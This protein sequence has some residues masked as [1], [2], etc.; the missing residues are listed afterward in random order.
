MGGT[1]YPDQGRESAAAFCGR[2]AGRHQ[3]IATQRR[4]YPARGLCGESTRLPSAFGPAPR[5]SG[6]PRP[7]TAKELEQA[8]RRPAS[9]V[10][11]EFETGLDRRI[12]GDVGDEPGNLPLL[13]FVL[14]ELW[15]NRQRGQLL[16]DS[17]D[18]MGGLQG[19]V[20]AKAEALFE[21][22]SPPEQEATRRLFLQLVHTA[23]EG[24]DTCRRVAI[25]DVA[26]T[27]AGRVVLKKLADARLVTTSGEPEAA[28]A[29][30]AHEALISGWRR[31]G[32]WVNENRERSRL[33][34]RLFD[35]AREWQKNGK[36]R[37]FLY[38]GAQLAAAEKSFGS[39]MQFLPQFAREFLEAS[40]AERN[41]ELKKRLR[42]LARLTVQWGAIIMF[43]AAWVQLFD[44]SGLD[45]SI[46]S[47]TMQLGS[48]FRRPQLDDRI[49]IVAKDTAWSRGH[50]AQL[51]NALSRAG[52]KSI[53]FDM[54]LNE[55]RP[56]DD[57]LI[58]AIQ[59]AKALGTA[60]I[61]GTERGSSAVASIEKAASG[62]G[63]LCTGGKGW[64][65]PT[66]S[67]PLAVIGKRKL[68]AH[69]SVLAAYP[70]GQ[71]E[72]IDQKNWQIRLR[73]PTCDQIKFSTIEKVS[74]PE[75]DCPILEKDDT[76]AQL[77]VELTPLEQLRD[78]TR[79]Y[80]FEDIFQETVAG[81]R[82]TGKIVLVGQE[83]K[84]DMKTVFREFRSEGRY[85]FE[86]H[87]DMLNA[88]LQGTRIRPLG[89]WEQFAVMLAMGIL[90][91]AP[92]FYRPLASPVW[93]RCCYFGAVFAAYVAFA[94]WLYVK[95]GILLNMLYHLGTMFITYWALGKAARRL[96]VWDMD[97]TNGA[98]SS[99]RGSA[100]R[101]LI[102]LALILA[103]AGCASTTT[104]KEVQG[105][106]VVIQQGRAITARSDLALKAGDE[107][108]T[109]PG[110]AVI[111]HFPGSDEVY[112]LP[113]TRVRIES[114]RDLIGDIFVRA[115]G[116][117]A[118]KTEFAT[119]GVEG[120]E[121]FVSVD[122]KNTVS[123]G[124]FKGRV[125]LES[126]TG[127]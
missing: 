102:L 12:L 22:L 23:E 57:K 13:E 125:I 7:E 98:R 87:A 110:S 94:I 124:V 104:V 78:P 86:I 39:S 99:A 116:L 30:L 8:V 71:I 46:A 2:A 105:S 96:G 49:A 69:L 20:A 118:V 55:P 47:F 15:D 83:K 113:Q 85:G 52:A 25:D 107:L 82:F 17:Y 11:L 56:D 37:D 38:R 48:L 18:R 51:I 75:G 112:V 42:R 5:R 41:R 90:G 77:I 10:G 61:F 127:L 58:A 21:K 36:G 27:E 40:V 73:T 60:V 74:K 53:A 119:A 79:R 66:L 95:D 101:H 68:A 81:D 117:F 44:L 29:E 35:S 54:Y 126:R 109:E 114:I 84:E 120:T 91:V 32:N 59:S 88:L 9:E 121:F 80:R 33:E 65:W 26:S 62:I 111:L 4:A 89:L 76:V 16:H 14:R 31:L 122:A 28:Q 50:E 63:L 108:Q 3:P 64:P 70:G 24:K 93:R 19:A 34:E 6:Q 100:L 1:L 67:S 92:L 115:K 106:A 45:T 123:V 43:I 103:Q 97:Y 72:E